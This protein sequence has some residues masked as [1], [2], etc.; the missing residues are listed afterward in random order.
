MVHDRLTGGRGSA[1]PIRAVG[2]GRLGPQLLVDFVKLAVNRCLALQMLT[3]QLLDQLM[4]WLSALVVGVMAIAEQELAACR[5]M[6]PDAPAA[7]A[8][9]NTPCTIQRTARRRRPPGCGDARPVRI[10]LVSALC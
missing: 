2:G 7:S 3:M 10:Q 1:G 8:T 4:S 6:L 9:N 5:G